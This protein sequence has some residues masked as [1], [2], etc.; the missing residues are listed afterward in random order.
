MLPEELCKPWARRDSTQSTVEAEAA[1]HFTEH[2]TERTEGHRVAD[3]GAEV[4][5]SP[6]PEYLSG[7]VEVK[8]QELGKV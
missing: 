8:L 1:F 7:H 3:I 5:F 2:T 6:W 4:L